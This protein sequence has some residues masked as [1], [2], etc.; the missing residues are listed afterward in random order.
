M[1]QEQNKRRHFWGVGANNSTADIWTPEGKVKFQACVC[2][3][4]KENLWK[5][6]RR[7]YERQSMKNMLFR[8]LVLTR[9]CP[10]KPTPLWNLDIFCTDL[11]N[12]SDNSTVCP[13]GVKIPGIWLKHQFQVWY[14]FNEKWA[15]LTKTPKMSLNHSGAHSL[16]EC[17]V[18][19]LRLS[20]YKL[21]RFNRNTQKKN[22][23]SCVCNLSIDSSI[24][25]TRPSD[26][27]KIKFHVF[28]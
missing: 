1:S 23:N 19:I 5:D 8:L 27:P 14:P 24:F 10:L 22:K 20:Q 2:S 16:N 3:L 26:P 28:R 21:K 9:R 12:V 13:N 25:L 15:G 6:K 18:F 4:T 11:E 7:I 17:V